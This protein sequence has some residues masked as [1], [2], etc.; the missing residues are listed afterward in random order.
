MWLLFLCI[1]FSYHSRSLLVNVSERG[2]DVGFVSPFCV[3]V[4]V[5]FVAPFDLARAD[6]EML[7]EEIQANL[8]RC[9]HCLFEGM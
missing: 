9:Q 7:N 8:L 6:L 2:F 4:N 5:L 3:Q 1:A